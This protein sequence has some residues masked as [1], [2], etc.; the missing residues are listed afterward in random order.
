M[1]IPPTNGMLV[2]MYSTTDTQTTNIAKNTV[3]TKR[4]EAGEGRKNVD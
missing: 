2:A 3:G 4:L 1:M